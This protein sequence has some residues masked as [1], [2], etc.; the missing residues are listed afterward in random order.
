MW[1]INTHIYIHA[2]AC[3]HTYNMKD[4]IHRLLRESI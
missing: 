2:H 1:H 4:L 3:M